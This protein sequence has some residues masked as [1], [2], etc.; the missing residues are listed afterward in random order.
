MASE[1][2]EVVCSVDLEGEGEE[3]RMWRGEHLRLVLEVVV[4]GPVPHC[5]D[6]S[7]SSLTVHYTD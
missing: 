3:G 6:S 1:M 4:Q 7:S 5:K 2:E